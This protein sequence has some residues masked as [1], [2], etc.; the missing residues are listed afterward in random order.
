M[1]GMFCE[2]MRHYRASH[3]LKSF[4]LCIVFTAKGQECIPTRRITYWKAMTACL[5]D[6]WPS[7]GVF[8]PDYKDLTDTV[9][10]A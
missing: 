2:I 3:N 5:E 4:F 9:R 10:Q 1:W 8:F 6:E 7:L